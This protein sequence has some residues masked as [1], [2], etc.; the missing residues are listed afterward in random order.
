L[1]SRGFEW[2]GAKRLRPG[3]TRR[4]QESKRRRNGRRSTRRPSPAFYSEEGTPNEVIGEAFMERMRSMGNVGM[5]VAVHDAKTK[6]PLSGMDEKK[7]LPGHMNFTYS[8]LPKKLG[9][10]RAKYGDLDTQAN[11]DLKGKPSW[12]DKVRKIE[13]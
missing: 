10:E 2:L 12:Q 5:P 8:E 11:K 3:R 6:A 4:R 7:P 13:G 9:M 1:G